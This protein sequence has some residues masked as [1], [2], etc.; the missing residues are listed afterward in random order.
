MIAKVAK[1]ST[2]P[3]LRTVELPSPIEWVPAVCA[4]RL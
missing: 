4:N 1:Y 3:V 2:G